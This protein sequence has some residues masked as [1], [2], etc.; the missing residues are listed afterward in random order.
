MSD[1]TLLIPTI[2]EHAAKWHADSEIVGRSIDKPD[3]MN[4]TTWGDVSGR[5]MQL[6]N[7][8]Q[9]LD[10]QPGDR[11]A[12]LAFSSFRHLELYYAVPGFGAVCHTINPR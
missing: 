9:R 12:T 6:A 8:L 3:T 10:V 4:R 2:L 5:A 11:V 7:A 1:Q